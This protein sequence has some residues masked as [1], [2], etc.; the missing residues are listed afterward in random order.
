MT[1]A[2]THH[3]LPDAAAS[4]ARLDARI[5]AARSF[6]PPPEPA[7]RPAQV[8]V[9]EVPEVRAGALTGPLL[10][11]AIAASGALLV[12]GLLP[13][14]HHAPL[15]SAIDAVLAADGGLGTPWFDPPP[16]LLAAMP[17]RELAISRAF[18]RSSGSAMCA[19]APAVAEYLLALYETLGLNTLAAHCLGGRPCLSVKKWV[20]RRSHKAVEEAGWHQDGAFMGAGIQS[21]NLWLPLTVCGADTGAPGL[22]IVPARID[23]LLRDGEGTF[24]W[25]VS[26]AYVKRELPPAE[27]PRFAAGDA[28]F[29]D[30]FFLHRTQYRPQFSRPRYAVETWFFAEGRAPAN[31]VPLSWR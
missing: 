30:H 26:P 29:F 31:Q 8:T 11:D 7:P 16:A 9:T 21:I 19:E 12:R 22:D 27:S 13:G 25:S 20:L 6:P 24:D 15:R 23:G 17:A 1:P 4:R 18:H 2:P 10:R 5:L 3:S 28:L 14:A